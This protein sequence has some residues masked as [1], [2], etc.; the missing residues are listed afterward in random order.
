[1]KVDEKDPSALG[2]G[3]CKRHLIQLVMDGSGPENQLKFR[4]DF[5][6]A[7]TLIPITVTNLSIVNKDVEGPEFVEYS[8]LTGYVLANVT[9]VTASSKGG[10]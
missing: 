1:M 3:R 4:I 10:V 9:N 2:V 8:G 6:K 5:L 7:G